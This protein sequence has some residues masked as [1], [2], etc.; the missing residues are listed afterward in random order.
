[1]AVRAAVP[2]VAI[3]PAMTLKLAEVEP[4]GTATEACIEIWALLLDTAIAAPSG[5]APDRVAVHE[6]DSPELRLLGRHARLVKVIR[7]EIGN[8]TELE[9]ALPGF[10]TLMAALPGPVIREAGTEALNWAVDCVAATHVVAKEVA[11]HCTTP[12]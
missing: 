10:T 12:C 7:G 1:M 2:A 6:V 5:A 9:L 8:E 4:A 11:F 3:F